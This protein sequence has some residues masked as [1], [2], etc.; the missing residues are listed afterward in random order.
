MN[1]LLGQ[2][3]LDNVLPELHQQVVHVRFRNISLRRR[4]IGFRKALQDLEV[5]ACKEVRKNRH[6]VIIPKALTQE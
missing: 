5:L 4:S 1:N 2:A 6:N 3:C